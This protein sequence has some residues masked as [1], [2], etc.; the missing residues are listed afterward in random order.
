MKVD[1]QQ[2]SRQ[3]NG[4]PPKVFLVAGPEMLLREEACGEIRQCLRQQGVVERDILEV[5]KGF[6]WN[7]LAQA[8]ASLS[9]FGDTRLI[10]LR[11][12]SG[13]I[14]RDGGEAI[15]H[16]LQSGSADYLLVSSEQWDLAS[17]KTA[18]ARSIDQQGL[19]IPCWNVK[20][21]R[22]AGWVQQRLRRH[23]LQAA[24]DAIALLCARV[25]G[26]LLA[27]AQEVEKLALI[28]PPGPVSLEAIQTAVADSAQFDVFRL[29]ECMLKG[30][31]AES[32][33]MIQGLLR[34]GEAPPLLV[35][36]LVREFQLVLSWMH[37]APRQGV[38]AAFK[39]LGIW[40]SRQG[41]VRQAAQ[42][43]GLERCAQA[44]A[45]LAQLDRLAKGQLRGDFATAL[46]RFALAVTQTPPADPRHSVQA[47]AWPRAV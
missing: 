36:L 17:E 46:E 9:L 44:L 22:L 25:E 39:Q 3:L 29:A 2:L 11:L 42:R 1:P 13:K 12:S 5:D 31:G 45:A 6:D 30:Q 14:G 28:L 43:L 40:P 34:A 7:Q 37:A 20:P 26:N 18:W 47:E 21:E 4:Q 10:E 15:Q 33:R 27:A 16:W 24:P 19:Y 23:Q 32:L 41:P 38:D 35:G 8:G